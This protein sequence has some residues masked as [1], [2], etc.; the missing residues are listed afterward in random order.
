MSHFFLVYALHWNGAFEITFI[1]YWNAVPYFWDQLKINCI[2]RSSFNKFWALF[3]VFKQFYIILYRNTISL[4][5]YSYYIFYLLKFLISMTEIKSREKF[6][7]KE[8]QYNFTLIFHYFISFQIFTHLRI[9]NFYTI[10]Y[11]FKFIN[12]LYQ[13]SSHNSFQIV[14]FTHSQPS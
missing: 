14:F 6:E 5:F 8:D 11:L 12:L 13:N 1:T 10:P 9:L 4:I 3:V 2:H 7:I